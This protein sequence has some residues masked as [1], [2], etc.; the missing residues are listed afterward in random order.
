MSDMGTA[1]YR[2]HA[3]VRGRVQG[4]GFRYWAHHTAQFLRG[5]SGY[6][7]NMPDGS[8]EVEAECPERTQL[9]RLEKE[10][11]QGPSTARVEIVD[12]HWEEGTSPRHDGF[13][14]A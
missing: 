13:H 8:V 2:M 9:E 7:R 12:V 6:V 10:L 1:V 11:Y 5:V 3:T 14:V 4:V